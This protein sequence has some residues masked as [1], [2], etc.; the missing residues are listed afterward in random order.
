MH[1]QRTTL[2]C[3]MGVPNFMN[4]M[5]HSGTSISVPRAVSRPPRSTMSCQPD[6]CACIDRLIEHLQQQ[7]PG[8]WAEIAAAVV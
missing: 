5:T 6:D 8:L 1:L 2:N 3:R 7:A 4:S